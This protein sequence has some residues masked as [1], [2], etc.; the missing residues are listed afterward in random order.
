MS[1]WFYRYDGRTWDDTSKLPDQQEFM[2]V[3][4]LLPVFLLEILYCRW[5]HVN[6]T[7]HRTSAKW[8][9][10]ITVRVM[11]IVCQFTWPTGK[12]AVTSEQFTKWTISKRY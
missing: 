10:M 8:N 5:G 1:L 9:W 7:S 11:W 3:A 4:T 2:C 12:I 6:S